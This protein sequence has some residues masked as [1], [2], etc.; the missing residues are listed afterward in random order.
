VQS[1]G[2]GLQSRATIAWQYAALGAFGLVSMLRNCFEM[3]QSN[4]GV[5]IFF[6]WVASA[7]ESIPLSESTVQSLG[8]GLRSH[9]TIAWQCA[10]LG[11]F[12]L[13]S[14]LR[15]CF[16]LFQSNNHHPLLSLYC[17][18]DDSAWDVKSLG[19][20][21]VDD[22]ARDVIFSDVCDVDSFARDVIPLSM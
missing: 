3:F 5:Q 9:A 14:M 12:G 2:D 22:F 11:A 13:V 18:V 15:N 16:E 1:L 20:C 4:K 7:L 17:A 21:A 6:S 19:V 8:S 10:A